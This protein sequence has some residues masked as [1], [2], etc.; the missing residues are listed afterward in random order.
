MPPVFVERS[1]QH[2]FL[3]PARTSKGCT[4]GEVQT[5]L[6]VAADERKGVDGFE[7][8]NRVDADHERTPTWTRQIWASLTTAKIIPAPIER[9]L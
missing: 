1:S 3:L 4:A 9:W 6:I 7:Q 8:R 2:D 5:V